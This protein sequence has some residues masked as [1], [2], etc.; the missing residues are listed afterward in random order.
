M[1]AN[2]SLVPDYHENMCPE[3]LERLAKAVYISV[4]PDV[5]KEQLDEQVQLIAKAVNQSK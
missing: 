5:G 1:E 3:T 4:S 2:R